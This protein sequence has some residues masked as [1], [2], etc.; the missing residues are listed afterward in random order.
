MS[1]QL[2]PPTTSSQVHHVFISLL[3]HV[4]RTRRKPTGVGLLVLRTMLVG[5]PHFSD[6]ELTEK[7]GQIFS[8]LLQR[9]FCCQ[10]VLNLTPLN[11]TPATCHKRKRKLH[12]RFRSAAL[13]ELHCNIAFSAVRKSFGPT[14]ALQQTKTAL[15]HRKNCVARKWRFPAAF[16]RLS[17]PHV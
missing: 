3:L 10:Q 13:Q 5:T 9:C 8:G 17:S 2:W 12:C 11:P 1:P 6:P 14:A 7:V 16:L 4:L 15:Q